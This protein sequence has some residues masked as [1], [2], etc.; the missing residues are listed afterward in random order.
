MIA[1]KKLQAQR[2]LDQATVSMTTA[3]LSLATDVSATQADVVG[4]EDDAQFVTLADI[5]IFDPEQRRNVRLDEF[6]VG[7]ETI[8]EICRLFWNT[9][10]DEFWR[11]ALALLD[12]VPQGKRHL[13]Y[14]RKSL[15]AW[16]NQG[17]FPTTLGFG[18]KR[19]FW[20]AH[21]LEVMSRTVLQDWDA[22]RRWV[23][24]NGLLL[25]RAVLLEQ[26]IYLCDLDL[27]EAGGTTSQRS[28]SSTRRPLKFFCHIREKTVG[29][30]TNDQLTPFNLLT[31][32]VTAARALNLLSK[33]RFPIPLHR[34]VHGRY[35][36]DTRQILRAHLQRALDE[37]TLPP[38]PERA[39]SK[40]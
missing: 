27:R 40:V 18:W 25:K 19:R 12:T 24:T 38:I 4:T 33:K 28:P 8:E 3:L 11:H 35:V 16:A 5:V 37:T 32:P 36:T 20:L 30:S 39:T 21:E 2:L 34:G 7:S 22:H 23:L 26:L 9:D 29:P 6:K 31:V 13:G 10:R 15:A 1:F 14:D 17:S